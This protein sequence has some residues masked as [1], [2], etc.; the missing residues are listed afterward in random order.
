MIAATSTIGLN[1]ILNN[2]LNPPN[3]ALGNVLKGDKVSAALT[4]ELTYLIKCESSGNIYAINPHD[5]VSG[6]FGLVQWKTESFWHY[7]QVYHLLPDLQREE[8]VNIIYDP[9]IQ[10]EMAKRVLEEPDGW[11]NWYVCLK[12]FH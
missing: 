8:V 12:K 10:I 9:T 7:N 4:P 3:Q 11:K 1:G 2:A 5:P 6:S